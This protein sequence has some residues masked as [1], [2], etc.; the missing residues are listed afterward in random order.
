MAGRLIEQRPK[1]L[2]QFSTNLWWTHAENFKTISWLLFELLLNDW[3][4]VVTNGLLL[5]TF[6]IFVQ[7]EAICCNKFSVNQQLIKDGWRY[8]LEIFSVCSSPVCA[9]LTKKFRPLLN[10][11]ASHGPFWP[12]LWT[13]LA[14]VLVDIFWKEKNWVGFRPFPMTH[15][16]EF[17]ISWKKRRFE[18]FWSS[19]KSTL[20]LSTDYSTLYKCKTAKLCYKIS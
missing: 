13:S 6:L 14:T 1:F 2:C 5:Y 4:F 8:L 3:K 20:T 10:Q 11:P 15:W 18:I 12:K 7:Q 16:K 17:L 19:W 9:K